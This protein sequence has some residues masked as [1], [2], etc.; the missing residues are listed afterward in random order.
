M[1]FI[2]LTSF[3]I[4]KGK[5]LNK[6][7]AVKSARE[8]KFIRGMLIGPHTHSKSIKNNAFEFGE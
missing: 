5:I 7:I 2:Q 8:K 3:A 4:P 6:L 1:N